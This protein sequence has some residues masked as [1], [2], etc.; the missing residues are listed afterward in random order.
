L[1]SKIT[2]IFLE[3]DLRVVGLEMLIDLKL[4]ILNIQQ[5]KIIDKIL[6]LNYV[7]I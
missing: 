4:S 5:S 6:F 7:S 3:D 2:K 1:L